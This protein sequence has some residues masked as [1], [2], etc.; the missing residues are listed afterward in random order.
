MQSSRTM[1]H[2]DTTAV[3]KLSDGGLSHSHKEKAGTVTR[4]A[5]TKMR[6]KQSFALKVGICLRNTKRTPTL[7]AFNKMLAT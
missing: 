7:K 2:M 4:K 3:S 1:P 5:G 6:L